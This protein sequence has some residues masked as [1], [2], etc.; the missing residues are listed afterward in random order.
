[1]DRLKAPASGSEDF[2]FMMEQVPGAYINLGNGVNSASIHNP[3]YN[4]DDDAIPFGAAMFARVVERELR[5]D[6]G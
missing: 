6:V 2:S 1:V 5:R 3:L 4:F